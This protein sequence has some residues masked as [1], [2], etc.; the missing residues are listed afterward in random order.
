MLNNNSHLRTF[1]YQNIILHHSLKIELVRLHTTK[2]SNCNGLKNSKFNLFILK[3]LGFN[4]LS[5]LNLKIIFIIFPKI[6]DGTIQ[7]SH[8]LTGST[9]VPCDMT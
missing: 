7:T 9:N 6:Y 1:F 3:K 8:K 5:I 4:L 2:S